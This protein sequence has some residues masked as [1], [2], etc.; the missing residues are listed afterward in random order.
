M[1]SSSRTL[2]AST[3]T[4]PGYTQPAIVGGL[5]LGVLSALPLISAGNVCCC[6]WIVG[7]GLIAA[8]L[9]QQNYTTPIQAAD[10]ALVG[11]LA[12][13]VGAV[14]FLV[15]SIPINILM[16][17]LER[18]L[19]D[20]LMETSAAFPSDFREYVGSTAGGVIGAVLGFMLMLF[21]GSIF[22]TLGGLLG[23]VFF[24][25]RGSQSDTPLQP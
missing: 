2:D 6:M 1:K 25:R 18:A 14:V 4:R 12:G 19:V 15:L 7:G 17:P 16:G 23:V 5:F 8:Y 24:A 10:G 13:L 20:R 9:L 11:F 22:A 3:T 21:V